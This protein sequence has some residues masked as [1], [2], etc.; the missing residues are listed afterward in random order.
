[1]ATNTL[2]TSTESTAR[3]SCVPE[4][5]AWLMGDSFAVV[6]SVRSSGRGSVVTYKDGTP[7]A[8]EMPLRRFLRGAKED[9]TAAPP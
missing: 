5:S 8:K 3:V 9:P 4:G 2:E 1:M 6:S 7:F